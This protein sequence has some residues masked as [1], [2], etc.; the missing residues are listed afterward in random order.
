M[1]S[2]DNASVEDAA[3]MFSTLVAEGRLTDAAT[4]VQHPTRFYPTADGAWTIASPGKADHSEYTVTADVA[5]WVSRF[6]TGK[7][8]P[9]T[10][11]NG[12]EASDRDCYYLET[13]VMCDPLQAIVRIVPDEG[14]VLLIVEPVGTRTAF[15]LD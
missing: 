15:S 9:T 12:N 11:F 2:A 1:P 13:G 14:R 7:L 10:L 8:K 4:L 5:T 6:T 3:V